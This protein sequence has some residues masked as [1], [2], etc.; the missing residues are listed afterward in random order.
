MNIE[1][2]LERLSPMLAKRREAVER[3]SAKARA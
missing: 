2:A 1:A 3:A